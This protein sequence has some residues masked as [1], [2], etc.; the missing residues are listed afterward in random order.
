M[1]I[2]NTNFFH[3]FASSQKKK[4]MMKGLVDEQGVRHEDMDMMGAMVKEYFGN[5]FTREVKEID[6]GVLN[7]VDQKVSADMNQLLLA[8]FG[9][10]E[11]KKLFLV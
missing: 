4:N 2:E 11:V 8:P 7:D 5:L 3:N 6:D 10:E 9:R 1:V